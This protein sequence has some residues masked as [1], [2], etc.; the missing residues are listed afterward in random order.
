LVETSSIFSI[1]PMASNL[2]DVRGIN[3]DAHTRCK[4]YHGP[5]DIVAIKMKC[6]GVYYACKDCHAALAN[7][8]IE[9]WPEDEWSQKAILCG[10]CGVELTIRQYHGERI[11]LSGLPCAV[12]SEM[13]RTLSSLFPSVWQ[14][15][16]PR[17]AAWIFPKGLHGGMATELG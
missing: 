13:S 8:R 15:V 5:T 17:A 10:A 11:S 12:Q 7:H 4:H 14:S 6:C 1:Y 16:R 3:L 2:P 9:I